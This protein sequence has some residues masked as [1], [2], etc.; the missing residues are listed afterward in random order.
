MA[1]DDIKISIKE[2]LGD[3]RYFDY[4]LILKCKTPIINE[5]SDPFEWQGTY[6][7]K[8]ITVTVEKGDK[9]DFA[10]IEGTDG[11]NINEKIRK[12]IDQILRKLN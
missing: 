11:L 2:H 7:G 10:V 9:S 5:T 12:Q 4:P 6:N 1:Q 3:D 8:E